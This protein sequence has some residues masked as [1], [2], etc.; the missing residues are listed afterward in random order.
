MAAAA[1]FP[2][3]LDKLDLSCTLPCIASL[4]ALAG[5]VPYAFW[6]VR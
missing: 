3:Y 4:L 5:T 2:T 1:Q 6:H